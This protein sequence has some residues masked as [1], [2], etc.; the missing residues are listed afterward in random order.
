[1]Q[2]R[3]RICP[4]RHVFWATR[5]GLLPRSSRKWNWH[6]HFI[7]FH[8][9]DRYL[10]PSKYWPN[11]QKNKALVSNI[12]WFKTTFFHK[13]MPGITVFIHNSNWCGLQ[14]NRIIKNLLFEVLSFHYENPWNNF[15]SIKFSIVNEGL[16][17]PHLP[18]NMHKKTQNNRFFCFC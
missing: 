18:I 9:I 8:S 15:I 11:Y 12:N 14:R 4:S 13:N 16:I 5:V 7:S 6:W 2:Y 3:S 10:S 17:N 1:M